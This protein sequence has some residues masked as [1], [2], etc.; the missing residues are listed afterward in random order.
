MRITLNL[1]TRPFVELRPLFA[2][3]RIAIAVLALVATGLGFWLHSVTV[4]AR[5][6]QAQMTAL[7]SRTYAFEQERSGNESRMRTPQNAAVLDRSQFL[8]SI[9]ATKSFSWTSVLMDLENVLPAGVQVTSIDP[10]LTVEGDVVIRLRVAGDRDRTVQ[11][12]RN[13]ERSQRF[14]NARLNGEA[15]QT[16]EQAGSLRPVATGEVEFEIFA[17]YNP[18]KL[19]STKEPA[20]GPSQPVFV[21][22]HVHVS[23]PKVGVQ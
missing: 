19:P 18:L 2:R 10:Q 21:P 7:K 12:I 16:K 4:Q 17:G 15:L 23:A 14:V 22:A 1:A 11:L 13:L 8:N 6:A 3:L 9:F 20:T 5:A